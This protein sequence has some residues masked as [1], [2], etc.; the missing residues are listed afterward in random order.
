MM[1]IKKSTVSKKAPTNLTNRQAKSTE[2]QNMTRK[3]TT[4]RTTTMMSMMK[5]KN[6]LKQVL[7]INFFVPCQTKIETKFTL[8]KILKKKATDYIQEFSISLQ[9]WQAY[10]SL[11][12]FIDNWM[13]ISKNSKQLAWLCRLEKHL[14]IIFYS[15][16]CLFLFLLKKSD[17]KM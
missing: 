15:F 1:K 13:K 5:I 9:D 2:K 6:F 10:A 7:V 4:M 12:P 8:W 3:M 17:N 11:H 16:V 14:G